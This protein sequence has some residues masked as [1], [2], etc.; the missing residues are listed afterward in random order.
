MP[1]GARRRLRG[2]APALSS[3]LFLA[4]AASGSIARA[5]IGADLRPE[6]DKFEERPSENLTDFGP[7]GVPPSHL[8]GRVAPLRKCP[9]NEGF[10]EG[11]K[12]P[13]TT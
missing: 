7:A 10:N 13:A 6:E 1:L 3:P 12:R 9:L 2:A 5:R 8:S 4:A 11:N